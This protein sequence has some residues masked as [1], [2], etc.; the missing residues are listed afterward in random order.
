MFGFRIITLSNG[1]QVIDRTLKTPYD[2]L[3]LVE[4]IEYIEM[5]KQMAIM[6]SIR[7][8]QQKE[9]KRRQKLERNPLWR[10]ACFCGL[11]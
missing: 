5:D 11:V 3:A 10:F 4:M 8:R 9:E 1:D 6:D 7:K 2:S